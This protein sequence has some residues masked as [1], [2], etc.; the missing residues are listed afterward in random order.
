MLIIATFRDDYSKEFEV[1]RVIGSS[2][3]H[4]G[5]RPIKLK[6]SEELCLEEQEYLNSYLLP[7]RLLNKNK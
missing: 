5:L 4:N 3:R 7:E 1:N 6:C 2:F